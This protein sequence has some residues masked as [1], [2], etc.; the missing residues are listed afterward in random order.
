MLVA[1]LKASE[2]IVDRLVCDTE[3]CG[4][5]MRA[6]S[7]GE[8]QQRLGTAKF[9]SMTGTGDKNFQVFF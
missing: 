5:L 3:A 1:H 6:F 8:P 4:D 7:L 2:P 9:M